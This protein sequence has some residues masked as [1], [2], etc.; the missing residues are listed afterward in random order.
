M[1]DFNVILGLLH[2]V[3]LGNVTDIVDLHVLS[4]KVEV[5]KVGEFLWISTQCDNQAPELILL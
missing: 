2:C 4:F 5:Y 1:I 3:D